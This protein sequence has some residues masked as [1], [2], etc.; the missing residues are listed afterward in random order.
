[1]ADAIGLGD[2]T[3]PETIA[4][5]FDTYLTSHITGLELPAASLLAILRDAI[6]LDSSI[7]RSIAAQT[8][9]AIFRYIGPLFGISALNPVSATADA[10]FTMV[11]S[12]SYEIPAGFQLDATG[13]D[14]SPVGFATI[15][16]ATITGGSGT[17]AIEAIDTGETANDLSGFM[18]QVNTLTGI[19][20]VEIDGVSSGGS[21]GETDDEYEGR[22]SEI[23]QLQSPAPILP[24]DFATYIRTTIAGV[25]RAVSVDL[26]D[27]DTGLY[28]QERFVCTFAVDEAGEAVTSGIL[29]EAEAALQA[30]REATFESPVRAPTYTEIDV[31]FTVTSLSTYDDTDVQTRA[32]AAVEDMLSPANWGVLPGGDAATWVNQDT[33]RRYEII[34]LLNNVEGVD[35][36]DEVWIAEHLD[37]AG[38]VDLSLTGPAPLTRAGDVLN[39]AP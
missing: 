11:D 34:A 23:L 1:M 13:S 29:T 27:P 21:D 33:V 25:Y 15:D 28:D 7:L 36:V 4:E 37:T 8:G 30:V 16:T 20:T 26:Y 3:D 10:I 2:E 35:Y 22:L 12:A 6:S 32:I 17:I 5:D 38:L 9:S 24:D 18:T 19:D 39:T 14:G 31:W